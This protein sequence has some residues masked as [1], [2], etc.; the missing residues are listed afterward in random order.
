MCDFFMRWELD[1]ILYRRQHCY[2]L[3]QI[4]LPPHIIMG[5]KVRSWVWYKTKNITYSPIGIFFVDALSM[6]PSV[7]G[8]IIPRLGSSSWMSTMTPFSPLLVGLWLT[9]RSYSTFWLISSSL[10]EI[11]EPLGLEVQHEGFLIMTNLLMISQ[12][13]NM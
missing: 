9:Y 8:I 10:F 4:T 7:L 12:V 13:S 1:R 6:L 3:T 11:N 2:A 5:W